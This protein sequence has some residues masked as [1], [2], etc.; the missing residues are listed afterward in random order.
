MIVMAGQ[1]SMVVGSCSVLVIAS[2]LS[3]DCIVLGF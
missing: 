3:L 1:V 2:I